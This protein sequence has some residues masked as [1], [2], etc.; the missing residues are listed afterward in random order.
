[1]SLSRG[2]TY[3]SR[4]DKVRFEFSVEWYSFS[5]Q[6]PSFCC[7]SSHFEGLDLSS[8]PIPF[9]MPF[10]SRNTASASS[11]SSFSLVSP[12]PTSTF[13]PLYPIQIPFPVLFPAGYTDPFTGPPF[14]RARDLP[15][16][17]NPPP[18]PTR[19]PTVEFHPIRRG[20]QLTPVLEG[21][22]NVKREMG[23]GALEKTTVS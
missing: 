1:M 13:P 16:S 21:H 9:Q 17:R 19:Q 20:L 18:E 3:L 15:L 5:N 6:V 10:L 23:E 4:T 12:I 2:W 14:R 7:T 11:A 8:H 22:V